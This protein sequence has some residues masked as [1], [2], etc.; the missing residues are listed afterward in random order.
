MASSC[1][2]RR[3]P[4]Y[5]IRNVVVA[6][7]GRYRTAVPSDETAGTNASRS[8]SAQRTYSCARASISRRAR[9]AWDGPPPPRGAP[10]GK[11]SRDTLPSKA[12]NAAEYRRQAE[13]G[14]EARERRPTPRQRVR[15]RV[16]DEPRPPAGPVRIEPL[17]EAEPGEPGEQHLRPDRRGVEDVVAV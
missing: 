15:V 1:M 9:A 11:R 12:I 10:P 8:S 6:S 17:V 5:A 14:E 16:G 13:G 7:P 2:R 3:S 4:S